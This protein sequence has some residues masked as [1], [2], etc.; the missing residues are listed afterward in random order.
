ME[1][2]NFGNEPF[3]R[4]RILSQKFGREI[5]N[6]EA[7]KNWRAIIISMVNIPQKMSVS[8]F[9]NSPVYRWNQVFNI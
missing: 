2:E 1:N 5:E 3:D 7:L 4:I 6:S 9:S 8:E